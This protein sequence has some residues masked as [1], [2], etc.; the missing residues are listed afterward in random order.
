MIKDISGKENL[1]DKGPYIIA[2]N[3]RSAFDPY[4]IATLIIPR[5]KKKVYFFSVKVK[6]L[7]IPGN[8]L[9]KQWAGCIMVDPKNK[10]ESVKQAISF[11]KKKKVVGIFPEGRSHKE[12]SLLKSRTGLA[13]VLIEKN[14]PVIPVGISN[15]I[16]TSFEKA[17]F[18]TFLLR[19][20]RVAINVGKPI[21]FDVKDLPKKASKEELDKITRVIMKNIGKLANLPYN[22]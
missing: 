4:F 21:H 14:V 1:P 12:K 2:A 9:A 3:H 7:S 17:F 16:S 20:G 10:G 5:I 11:L 18:Q 22:Y 6:Y 13:R 8:W 19:S 15:S